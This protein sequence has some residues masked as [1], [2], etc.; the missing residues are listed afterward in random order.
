[1]AENR[2]GQPRKKPRFK[3]KLH[4][5]RFVLLMCFCA[6]FFVTGCVGVSAVAQLRTAFVNPDK[7][8][9][10]DVKEE[11]EKVVQVVDTE[12]GKVVDKTITVSGKAVNI[13]V[14]GVD[15]SEERRQTGEGYN[16][17]VL[18]LV[19]VNTDTNK[20]TVLSIPRDTKA[21][22]RLLNASGELR[23]TKVGK[24]NSAYGNSGNIEKYGYANTIAAVSDVL[25]GISIDGYAA[26]D[27]DG[28]GK[29]ADLVG[30]VPLVMDVSIPEAG[31]YKD[32]EVL[33]RGEQAL[34]YVRER[35]LAGTDGSDVMRTQRQIRFVKAWM[36]QVK[37]NISLSQ[38]PGLYS[39]AMEFTD[40]DLTLDQVVALA[41]VLKKVDMENGLAMFN[42]PISY[43]D[44]LVY[45][46]ETALRDLVDQYFR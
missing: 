7:V 11:T 46:D 28:V 12:T 20:I 25:G 30:G 22:I 35:K 13:L 18:M 38:I 5:I 43:M 27:M 17:D 1:M 37:D 33:L 42:M 10:A 36:K 15:L 39:G 3:T 21:Q 45:P 16:T 19:N 23:G 26:I 40:T 41:S 9:N 6:L 14:I 29:M 8:F 31:L 34:A 4:L 44:D 24:I 32:E 2:T